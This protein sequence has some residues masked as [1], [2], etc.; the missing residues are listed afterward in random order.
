MEWRL[1]AM[2]HGGYLPH[3]DKK[4]L[5]GHAMSHAAAH[6]MKARQLESDMIQVGSGPKPVPA[7]PTNDSH[8]PVHT[9]K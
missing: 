5:R 8:P 2:K 1:Q 9:L 6:G 7:T 3:E 4:H